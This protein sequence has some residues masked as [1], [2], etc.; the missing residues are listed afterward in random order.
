MGNFL[1]RLLTIGLSLSISL[2][3]CSCSFESTDSR[4][5]EPQS[6]TGVIDPNESE[7]HE[8]TLVEERL[9]ENI[10]EE[11]YLTEVILAENKISEMLIQDDRI[12]EVLLC[13][14]IYVPQ[15]NISEF[16]KHSRTAQIFGDD[17]EIGPL[18]AKISIGT[19]VI[20][21]LAI[22]SITGIEG[23]VGSIIAAAA[24][25][26]FKGAAIGTGASTLIGGLTGATDE[27]AES[28][29]TS[30]II[31]FAAAI[32]GFVAA[33]ISA[34]AAIP[35]GGST[36]AGAAF[37]IK[38]AMAGIALVSAAYAGY[39]MVKSLT[40]TDAKAIDW[41]NVDWDSVGV[42]AAEQA[43]N[44]A[45]DGYVWGSIIGAV[46]GGL[47]GLEF[48]EK[49]GTPYSEYNL[50]I[51][52][53]PPEGNGGH[54]TGQR[55]ESTFVLDEPLTCKDG[56]IVTQITYQNGVPDFSEYAYR[57]VTISS[58]TN[59]R[60]SNFSQADQQ[61]ARDWSKIGFEGK[62]SWTPRDVSNYRT[63]HGLTWHEM[64]NMRTM[65][66]VPTEINAK[67]GHLGGV[68][69]YNAMVSLGG[70]YD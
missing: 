1:K 59:H 69:E 5:L 61:L 4:S 44:S 30:A 15:A 66:L 25:A 19:G 45:A 31:G 51:A 2:G 18:I 58:M 37:G 27:I 36:A 62:T 53:T 47:K 33:T 55:G 24:P 7:L 13:Q 49:Y 3:I 56:T 32:S 43:I 48:Y 41:N 20:L 46:E 68:G 14:T 54:W 34:I 60:W 26:A 57:Q 40:T 35:T 42:S 28:G 29:R 11:S 64:N 50:R 21:T 16:A 8:S 12:E 63:L 38:L 10:L 22:L 39:N 65:Q 52:R 9:F 17:V 67:F 23:P 70:P 6:T